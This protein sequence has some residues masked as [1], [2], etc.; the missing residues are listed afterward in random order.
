MLPRGEMEKLQVERLRAGIDRMS[1]TVPFYK[2][3]LSEAGVV[4][5]SIRSLGDLDRLPLPPKRTCVT[6]ILSI[7]LPCR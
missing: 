2:K 5:D 4:A 7:C 3:K 1:K 6:I